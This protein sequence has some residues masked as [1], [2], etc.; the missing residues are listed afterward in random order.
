MLYSVDWLLGT[1]VSGQTIGPTFKGQAAQ[2]EFFVHCLIFEDGT[3]ELS[4][5][6]SK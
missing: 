5:N 2:E 6:V 3:D 1:E 4:R